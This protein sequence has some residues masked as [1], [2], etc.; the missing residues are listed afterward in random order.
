MTTVEPQEEFW[1]P[2]TD[3][4]LCRRREAEGTIRIA[5]AGCGVVGSAL[6][7][8]LEEGRA[9]QG[10]D[11]RPRLELVRVLVRDQDKQRAP[12]LEPA[13]ATSSVDQFLATP[14]AAR[15]VRRL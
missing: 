2:A 12:A 7:R 1:E 13:L 4:L 11:A 9:E 3:P 5:L 10:W 14:S 8:L 15:R 6:V